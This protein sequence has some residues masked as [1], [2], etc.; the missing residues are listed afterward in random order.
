MIA[1]HAARERGSQKLAPALR[2][3]RALEGIN[4]G[5]WETDLRTGSVWLSPRFKALLGYAEDALND[6]YRLIYDHVHPADLPVYIERHRQAVASLGSF[7]F[8]IRVRHTSGQYR[9]MRGR[10]RVWPDEWGAPALVI[11]SV[12]DIQEQKAAQ[13]ALL[14]MTRRFERAIAASREGLFEYRIGSDDYYYSPRFFELLGRLP[15]DLPAR[16]NLVEHCLHPGDRDRFERATLE[17]MASRQPWRLEYRL[18]CGSGEYRWFRE[19]CC[20]TCGEDGTQLLSG[21]ITD[22]HEERRAREEV[23]RAN[24]AKS[25]FLA[26]MS[27]EIRTPMHGVLGML[28]LL[29]AA[30]LPPR[31]TANAETALRSAR[32][33]LSIVDDILDFSKVEAGKLSIEE[34]DF[35]PRA[36]LEEVRQLLQRRALEKGLRLDCVIDEKVPA[37]LRGDPGR[38]AQVL[39]NLADNALKFTEAGTVRLCMGAEPEPGTSRCMLAVS[40]QDSGIG[41]DADTLGRLFMPFMQA[42]ASMSRRFGGT[43]L[44]LA[45]CKQLVEL[46]GGTL[47]AESTPGQGSCFRLALPLDACPAPPEPATG[48]KRPDGLI[49]VAGSAAMRGAKVLVCEDNPVNQLVAMYMLE[50]LGCEAIVVPNGR[51]ALELCGERRFDLVLMDCQMPEMDGFEALAALRQGRP[52]SPEGLTPA[53]VPVI[54]MTAHALPGDGEHCLATGFDGYLSKPYELRQLASVIG[55][56]L[57]VPGGPPSSRPG[58]PLPQARPSPAELSDAM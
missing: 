16:R 3:Q 35:E 55:R 40:V 27:H 54:A 26:N 19:H 29:R 33:L 37:R 41:M 36:L 7:D 13:A 11:G 52:G 46:M 17:G 58:P 44:G 25:Q 39:R 14:Q 5:V 57:R 21:V 42:D 56:H 23:E 18:A 45:I 20:V 51:Q 9:W 10:G 4:A 50:S 6:S 28:E 47:T 34:I 32:Q 2:A 1:R 31:Q 12:I 49:P 53:D 24:R 22:I 43:G 48:H 8:E 30:P 15:G 38:I